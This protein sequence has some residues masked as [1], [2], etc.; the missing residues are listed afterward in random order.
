MY[1]RI[2]Y[3]INIP[4]ADFPSKCTTLHFHISGYY[5]NAGACVAVI[6][7]NSGNIYKQ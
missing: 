2:P 1:L 3:A 6:E 4:V 5:R 7:K